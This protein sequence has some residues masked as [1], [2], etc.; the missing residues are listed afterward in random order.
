LLRHPCRPKTR[1]DVALDALG[2]ALSSD[3]SLLEELSARLTDLAHRA[4]TLVDIAQTLA[5]EREDEISVEMLFWAQA[6]QTRSPSLGARRSLATVRF[7]A[8]SPLEQ[9]RFELSVP[10]PCDD[11]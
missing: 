5:S 3:N 11:A 10:P 8:N 9:R 2:A 7:V 6:T 1:V 4:A